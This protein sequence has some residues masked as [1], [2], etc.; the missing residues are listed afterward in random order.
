MRD[1]LN[2]Y[3]EKAEILTMRQFLQHILKRLELAYQINEVEVIW[4]S[5][6]KN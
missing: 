1:R 5:H 2:Q 6:L 3:G 4:K